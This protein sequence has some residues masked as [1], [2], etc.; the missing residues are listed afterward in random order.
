[1]DFNQPVTDLIRQRASTRTYQKQALEA[2]IRESLAHYLEGLQVGPLG[3]PTRFELID[4]TQGDGK[5]LRGLGTYGFIKDAAGFMIGTQRAGEKN[6]EDFGYQMERAILFATGLGLGTCWLGGTFT[7]S[8]FARKIDLGAEET[9]PAVTA[10]GYAAAKERRFDHGI[11]QRARADRRLPWEKLFFDT[12]LGAPLSREAAGA[13]TDV[14]E[15][16]RRGPSASNRQPW[17]VVKAGGTWHLYLQRSP[18]YRD[19]L[20]ARLLQLADLQR[21]DMGIAMC[22]FELAAREAGLPGGWHLQDP[23]LE[24]PDEWTEYCVSWG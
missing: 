13:F 7:K 12:R 10:V 23:G 14:L 17:R 24:I 9:I 6:L 21:I 18:G 16:V 1:M 22:H 4:S 2:D 5:Y 11:R 3:N 19:G 15:M 8:R 20:T